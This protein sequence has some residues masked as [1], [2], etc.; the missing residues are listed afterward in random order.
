VVELATRIVAATEPCVQV[1]QCAAKR[2]PGGILGHEV[3]DRRLDVLQASAEIA[4]C[5][6]V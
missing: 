3:F 2:G 4:E 1:G 6:S 5:V